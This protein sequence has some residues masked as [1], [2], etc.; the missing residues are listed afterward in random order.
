MKRDTKVTLVSA[1][2]T[3]ALSVIAGAYGIW[4][5]KVGLEEGYEKGHK[6]G[7]NEGYEYG[8]KYANVKETRDE[9]EEIKKDLES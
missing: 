8:F 2:V 9:Q 1:L 5:H 7:I 4:S 3:G 6:D